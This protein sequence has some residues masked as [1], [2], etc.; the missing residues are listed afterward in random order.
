VLTA[1][2]RERRAVPRLLL[3]QRSR[4]PGRRSRAQLPQGHRPGRA[5]H[6]FGRRVPRRVLQAQPPGGH[7][8]GARE[9]PRRGARA[10]EGARDEDRDDPCEPERARRQGHGL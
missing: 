10:G 5:C 7:H 4:P 3:R 2:G 1:A 6:L 8:P 9:R